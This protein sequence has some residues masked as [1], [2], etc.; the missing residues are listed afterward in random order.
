MVLFMANNEQ[1]AGEAL[2]AGCFAAE[3]SPK[4]APTTAS[5]SMFG[6]SHA[7]YATTIM[8]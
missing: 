4:D 5:V 8:M 6:P 1:A 7:Y 3:S 2:G